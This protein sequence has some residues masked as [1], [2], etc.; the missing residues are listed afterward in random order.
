MYKL[1]YPVGLPRNPPN[2]LKTN[3]FTKM[4]E[5]EN[6]TFQYYFKIEIGKKLLMTNFK[7]YLYYLQI[8]W[9]EVFTIVAVLCTYLP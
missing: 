7:E 4:N 8:Y 3:S 6:N 5:S 9:G 2:D 1:S